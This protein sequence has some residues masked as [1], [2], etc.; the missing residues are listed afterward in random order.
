MKTTVTALVLVLGTIASF[1][2]GGFVE[3]FSP[4]ARQTT[5]P[6]SPSS[7]QVLLKKNVD[8]NVVLPSTTTTTTTS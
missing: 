8:D 1:G 3:A 6:L 4:T 2:G 5:N 7:L